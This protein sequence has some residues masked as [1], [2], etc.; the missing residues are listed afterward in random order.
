MQRRRSEN[1]SWP[2]C[3]LFDEGLVSRETAEKWR[4]RVWTR[5][6]LRDA[7]VMA[8]SK[9]STGVKRTKK[10]GMKRTKGGTYYGH[11]WDEWVQAVGYVGFSI[12][13]RYFAR[14]QAPGSEQQTQPPERVLSEQ[15]IQ[16]LEA[17]LAAMREEGY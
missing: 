9:R 15:E 1:E 3:Y 8:Q 13:G 4:Q 16:R 10:S 6:E 14:P 12:P 7:G 17:L 2:W 11:T 5:A